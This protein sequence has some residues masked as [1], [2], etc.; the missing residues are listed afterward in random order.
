MISRWTPLHTWGWQEKNRQLEARLQS[1][2]R[3]VK[4]R[5]QVARVSANLTGPHQRPLLLTV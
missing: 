2:E 1:L 5:Q 3:T 4:A